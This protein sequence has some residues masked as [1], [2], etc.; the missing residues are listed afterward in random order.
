[1]TVRAA[2][3]SDAEEV[4]EIIRYRLAADGVEAE[5]EQPVVSAADF[6]EFR[7]GKTI[8]AVRR[9]DAG[10]DK[11]LREVT[12]LRDAR[13]ILATPGLHLLVRGA[14]ESLSDDVSNLKR[15]SKNA[16]TSFEELANKAVASDAGLRE[17]Y[18][19]LAPFNDGEGVVFVDKATR[20]DFASYDGLFLS[21]SALV[22]NE[23]KARLTEADVAV[24][25]AAH[26]S[27]SAVVANPARFTSRPAD[28][29]TVLRGFA[30]QHR[31]IV[32][33]L[34]STA[35]DAM[36]AAA[37]AAARVHVLVRTGEGFACTLSEADFVA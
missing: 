5:M 27:L 33:L 13:K 2:A 29:V 8:W 25:R 34:S 10:V 24:A 37:C 21:S 36:T 35:C 9:S 14:N 16:A 20:Q 30:G 22:F 31:T 17:R 1:V 26:A 11:K 12:R 32:P 3:A 28:A 18:G 23:S 19:A 6:D 15:E 4:E 7:K